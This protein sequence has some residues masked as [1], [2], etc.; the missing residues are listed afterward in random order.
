MFKPKVTHILLLALLPILA[1][2]ACGGRRA[3]PEPATSAPARV[4]AAPTATAAPTTTPKPEATATPAATSTPETLPT[5]AA[6]TSAPAEAPTETPAAAATPNVPIPEG[7]KDVTYDADAAEIAYTSALDLPALVKFYRQALPALGWQEDTEAAVVSGMFAS[8]DFK[9]GEDNTIT[10]TLINMNDS[11]Q[12]TLD[13]SRAPA[14]AGKPP[15]PVGEET[16]SAAVTPPPDAPKFT[17]KDWP[18]PPGATEVKQ[19]GE[20][21]SYKAPMKLADVAKFYR[22]TFTQMEFGTDCLDKAAEYTSMSCALSNGNFSLNFFAYE[23]PNN[24]AEVE[25]NF[26]NYNYPVA[27]A[28]STSGGSGS[29][30]LTAEDQDGLPMPSNNTGHSDEGTQFSRRLTVTSPS[31]APTLQKF[32]QTQLEAKGYKLAD[33]ATTGDITTQ[34]YTAEQGKL[35]VAFKPATGSDTEITLTKKDLAAATKAGILPPAGM[36]RI[37]LIN[38]ASEALA[39]TINNQTIN[40]AVGAGTDSPETAPKLDVKPGQYEVGVKAGSK[41]TTSPVTVGPDETWTL[42]LNAD[43]AAPLQMY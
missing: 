22:P 17:I 10:L 42:V 28:T 40:V 1:L 16:G 5:A 8:I 9:K 14:L 4:E 13:L 21:L 25:I 36:A 15:T 23:G 31:D 24:M 34:T 43:G 2:S 29:G 30:E 6:P 7:A 19:E 32:Y 12:A 27:G 20:K 37:Y 33:T 38:L 18:T 41:N 11:R 35:T 3:T 39:V 26:T